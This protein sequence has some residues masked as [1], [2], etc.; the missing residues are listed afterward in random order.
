MPLYSSFFRDVR[1][2]RPGAVMKVRRDAGVEHSSFFQLPEFPS[3]EELPVDER[4][5][6]YVSGFL[7]VEVRAIEAHVFDYNDFDRNDFAIDNWKVFSVS[8]WRLRMR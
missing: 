6:P 1:I 5:T 8:S 3:F 2:L 4:P 7:D